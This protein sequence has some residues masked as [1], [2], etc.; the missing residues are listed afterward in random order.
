MKNI[1]R[2]DRFTRG[3]WNNIERACHYH[4]AGLLRRRKNEQME[5]GAKYAYDR[6]PQQRTPACGRAHWC[7]ETQQRCRFHAQNGMLPYA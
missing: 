4:P 3:L 7:R 5:E 1:A 2:G 6:A